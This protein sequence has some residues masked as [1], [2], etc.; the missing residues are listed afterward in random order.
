MLVRQSALKTECNIGGMAMALPVGFSRQ[1]YIR[2][3]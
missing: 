2:R 1:I 3:L